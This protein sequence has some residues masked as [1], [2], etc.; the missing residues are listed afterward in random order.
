M[1]LK[2]NIGFS[3]KISEPH[4]SSRGVSVHLKLELDTS[5]LEQPAQLLAQIHDTFELA[6]AAVDAE[7]NGGPSLR[8]H[9][10]EGPLFA[11]HPSSIET[12]INN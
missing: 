11:S 7:L 9:H 10:S 4:F 1:S 12:T 3:R 5:L 8:C 6:H 2:A